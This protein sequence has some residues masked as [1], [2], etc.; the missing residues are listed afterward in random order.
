METNPNLQLSVPHKSK[1]SIL[2][3][4]LRV[5]FAILLWIQGISLIF[6]V[7]GWFTIFLGG[8]LFTLLTI[9]FLLLLACSCIIDFHLV[10]HFRR[11]HWIRSVVSFVLIWG[12][13]VLGIVLLNAAT[14]RIRIEGHSMDNSISDG[15][16][17]IVD[18]QAYQKRD[19]QRGDIVIYHRSNDP[20]FFY[21]NRIVGLP[22]DQIDIRDGTV[23][24]NNV[25][26]LENY[27]S[28][29]ADYTGQ[30]KVGDDQYFVLGDNRSDSSDS[31]SWGSLPRKNI[32]GK[33]VGAYWPPEI[34]GNSFL[35]VK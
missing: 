18:K 3:S 32:F 14:A 13:P 1:F 12:L 7:T 30:W 2:W 33:V 11:Q 16:Y 29:L 28:T 10:F 5:I 9:G 6:L 17:Y 20:N 24:V 31:H 35:S 22:G 27:V 25:P 8:R 23:Y 15:G 26:L 21:V 34:Y 4:I 19:P